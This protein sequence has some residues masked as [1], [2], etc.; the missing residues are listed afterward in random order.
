M[1]AARTKFEKLIVIS[2]PVFLRKNIS[3]VKTS[4]FKE[5]ESALL[6][7]GQLLSEAQETHYFKKNVFDEI[8]D[9]YMNFKI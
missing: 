9:G 5:L 6:D 1:F 3:L 7:L 2:F 8:T 4:R